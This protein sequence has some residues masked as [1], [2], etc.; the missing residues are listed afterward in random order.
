MPPSPPPTSDALT[1]PTPFFP[2]VPMESYMIS[3][4]EISTKGDET[5]LVSSVM[6]MA[7]RGQGLLSTLRNRYPHLETDFEPRYPAPARFSFVT[8]GSSAHLPSVT[9]PTACGLGNIGLYVHRN[10]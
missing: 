10:H 3:T 8:T 7:L 5:S 1:T 9:A 6:D 4:E 2:P